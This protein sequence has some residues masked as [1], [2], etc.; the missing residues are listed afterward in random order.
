[1]S[2]NEAMSAWNQGQIEA[3]RRYFETYR[4]YADK[5]FSEKAGDFFAEAGDRKEALAA[6]QHALELSPENIPVIKK[7]LLVSE[8][9]DQ[10]LLLAK[11]ILA[12]DHD[13]EVWHTRAKLLESKGQLPEAYFCAIKS[14]TGDEASPA[15]L[16]LK[17]ELELELGNYNIA[18]Q[19]L[20]KV[21]QNL[22]EEQALINKV[23]RIA[24]LT[25]KVSLLPTEL[26]PKGDEALKA[27]FNLYKR[28]EDDTFNPVDDIPHVASG[29][30]LLKAKIFALMAFGLRSAKKTGWEEYLHR[31][32][33]LNPDDILG[34]MIEG[35]EKEEKGDQK[36]A[37]EQYS[38]AL[39]VHTDS[40]GLISKVWGTPLTYSGKAGIRFTALGGGNMIGASCY[41]IET[42]SATIL[43]DCGVNLG[44]GNPL[45]ILD[46]VDLKKVDAVIL[47]HAHLDHC[48]A[49]PLLYA[50]NP[51]LSVYCTPPTRDLASIM[52]KDLLMP[53]PGT[54]YPEATRQNIDRAVHNINAVPFYRNVKVS[55][56]TWFE[57]YP[58][59]HILGAASVYINT[60]E[61]SILVT[62]D[63][64]VS[65]QLTV[66]PISIPQ[67]PV[68]FLIMESTYGFNDSNQAIDRESQEKLLVNQIKEVTD[69]GG[70]ILLPAFAIGRAQEIAMIL[71][72]H[73][74]D[75]ILPF[76]VYLDGRV[77]DV[78]DVYER[79]GWQNEYL[80]RSACEKVRSG[81]LFSGARIKSARAERE[82]VGVD[83]DE[84][85]EK[86][87]SGQ[88]A[89]IIASS[90]MLAEGSASS[91]YAAK[92]LADPKC[93][94]GITG[95][96]D[97][98]SPGA[99][100]LSLVSG[101]PKAICIE[102][103]YLL[104]RAE[105]ASF[106][107]SAHA[108]REELLQI[109]MNIKPRAVILVH[110]VFSQRS[111]SKGFKNIKKLLSHIDG[112]DTY[113][114]ING[115]IIDI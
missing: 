48:G 98:D 2:L 96:Q 73:F 14:I 37:I 55:S 18:R 54:I 39:A 56:S 71:K 31:C 15:H 102:D 27:C 23:I 105:V 67:R 76:N 51:D 111:A 68:D 5:N 114:S 84:F 30:T 33:E 101:S 19:T 35:M 86:E 91:R 8:N 81:P 61:G 38:L 70:T 92:V 88:G 90:G 109:V 79:Y 12:V 82:R 75:S 24:L 62:G 29:D 104:P 13:P 74:R 44:Q 9:I 25:D 34:Q 77:L 72:K 22:P 103:E 89:C 49:L 85:F 106:H 11:K 3:A 52:L 78:C 93:C 65:G 21:I 97:E 41:L 64:S 20:F 36:G 110:G 32:L 115:S 63:F 50:K 45:P 113:Q 107:L 57:F 53:S 99:Q 40:G 66:D 95:Y 10:A 58:A 100:L 4:L 16:V 46:N 80:S 94:I 7:M 42:G 1:M 108:S 59:G 43:V 6:Y 87:I 47:T 28:I 112:L 83:F 26:Q 69:R 60:P 17:A